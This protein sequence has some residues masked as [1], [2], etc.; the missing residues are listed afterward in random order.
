M[1]RSGLILGTG[2][3]RRRWYCSPRLLHLSNIGDNTVTLTDH[4][5]YPSS[6]FRCF[7]SGRD[8]RHFQWHSSLGEGAIYIIMKSEIVGLGHVNSF[9][10]PHKR[11]VLCFSLQFDSTLSIF[12]CKDLIKPYWCTGES[13]NLIS[14]VNRLLNFGG[15]GGGQ[16]FFFFTATS[17]WSPSYALWIKRMA[18][19][20]DVRSFTTTPLY[21]L[22][23]DTTLLPSWNQKVI[24]EV[25]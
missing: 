6:H 7:L 2:N 22:G 13:V 4:S 21:A 9:G 16:D 17:G 11:T 8:H 12:Y 19:D 25:F 23:T 10:G 3:Y 20:N 24:I 5:K 14:K 1:K 15:R 18:E